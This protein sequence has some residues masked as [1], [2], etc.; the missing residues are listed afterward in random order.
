MSRNKN[1]SPRRVPVALSIAL[2]AL[3]VVGTAVAGGGLRDILRGAEVIED[4]ADSRLNSLDREL[5]AL[6]GM[7]RSL[8]RSDRR[9]LRKRIARMDRLIDELRDD[10]DALAELVVQASE[11]ARPRRHVKTTVDPRGIYNPEPVRQRQRGACNK[12]DFK[13]VLGAVDTEWFDQGR[14]AV[15]KSAMS[16]RY[17][18]VAQ[19]KVLVGRFSFDSYQVDVAAML[20]AHTV[21]LDNWYQ[22][23]DALTFSSS[24]RELRKRVGV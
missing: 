1:F 24:K 20:H 13:N 5:E 10:T 6:R 16:E 11:E 23:Y 17:F 4:D 14:M 3:F 21:D 8:S 18:T 22:V 12:N 7:S 2:A 9:V 19:V 15:L